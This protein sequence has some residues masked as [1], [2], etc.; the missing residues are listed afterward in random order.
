[1]VYRHAV[2]PADPL[3]NARSMKVVNSERQVFKLVHDYSNADVHLRERLPYLR[4]VQHHLAKFYNPV[5]DNGDA[6]ENEI[7]SEMEEEGAVENLN[8]DYGWLGNVLANV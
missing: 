3:R 8:I 5:T 6:E 2:N 1:M 4:R 7:E